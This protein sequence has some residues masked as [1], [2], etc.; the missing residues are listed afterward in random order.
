MYLNGIGGHVTKVVVGVGLIRHVDGIHW[1]V[2][3]II[4]QLTIWYVI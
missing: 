3:A 4:W 1:Y 2:G